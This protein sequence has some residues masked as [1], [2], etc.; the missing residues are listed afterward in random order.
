MK[1]LWSI[2]CSLFVRLAFL[3]TVCILWHFDHLYVCCSC[4]W[5]PAGVSMCQQMTRRL[6]FVVQMV[7]AVHSVPNYEEICSLYLI[8]NSVPLLTMIHYAPKCLCLRFALFLH[9]TSWPEIEAS[10]KSARKWGNADS[11]LQC[12]SQWSCLLR[13]RIRGKNSIS[14]Y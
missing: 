7:L 14:S 5:Q 12:L 2:P 13:I 1:T 6:Y 9:Y 4:K 8:K 11:W 3:F 10:F